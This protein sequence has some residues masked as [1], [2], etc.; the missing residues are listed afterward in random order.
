[1]MIIIIIINHRRSKSHISRPHFINKS[2]ELS[3]TTQNFVFS[4]DLICKNHSHAHKPNVS[5]SNMTEIGNFGIFHKMAS[6]FC[7]KT[8]EKCC[9]Q[10]RWLFASRWMFIYFSFCMSNNP[11]IHYYCWPIGCRPFFTE[12]KGKGF[13]FEQFRSFIVPKFVYR[14]TQIYCILAAFFSG[15][16]GEIIFER[17]FA[18]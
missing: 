9:C 11:F 10:T 7:R 14:C 3:S 1:M 16:N 8:A 18:E 2:F 15:G 6:I 13:S 4:L 12:E 5:C 17:K